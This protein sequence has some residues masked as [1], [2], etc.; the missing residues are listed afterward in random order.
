MWGA[1][2]LLR[3]GGDINRLLRAVLQFVGRQLPG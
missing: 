2:H 3:S 1:D